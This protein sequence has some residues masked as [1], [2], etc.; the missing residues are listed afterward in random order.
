[1]YILLLL[2]GERSFSV[3]LNKPFV[4]PFPMETPEFTGTHG[5]LLLIVRSGAGG[6]VWQ[7]SLI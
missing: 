1:M 2:S 3:R 5:D 6:G 4:P 7:P